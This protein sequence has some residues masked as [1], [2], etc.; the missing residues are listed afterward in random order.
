MNDK[1]TVLDVKEAYKGHNILVTQEDIDVRGKNSRKTI[2]NHED[3]VTIIPIQD[4]KI[5]FVRQYRHACRRF[6][7][8]LPAGKM[9]KGE[10]PLESAQRELQEE[11]GMKAGEM[12]YL[13][14]FYLAPGYSTEF[15]HLFLATELKPSK[16]VEDMDEQIEVL[17]YPLSDEA[18]WKPTFLDAKTIIGLNYLRDCVL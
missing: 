6:L 11:I 16:L 4:G 8:E 9:D 18:L 13:F 15:M 3:C 5:Y 1:V 12:S 17:T 14:G 2:V 10:T 7:I